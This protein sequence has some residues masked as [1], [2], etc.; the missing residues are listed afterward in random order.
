MPKYD[1]YLNSRHLLSIFASSKKEQ[2]WRFQPNVRFYVPFKEYMT[3]VK[4]IL[5]SDYRWLA[6]PRESYITALNSLAENSD[7]LI[8]LYY[9]DIAYAMYY[10][11]CLASERGEGCSLILPDFEDGLEVQLTELSDRLPEF[12]TQEKME[13]G[14]LGVKSYMPMCMIIDNSN[15]A[16]TRNA[17]IR[18]YIIFLK[19]LMQ[20]EGVTKLNIKEADINGKD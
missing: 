20:Q 10:E 1:S 15:S 11:L 7:R 8:R 9:N 6:F 17:L 3:F 18:D 5:R 19:C 13:A 16:N 2:P 12:V 14:L 4:E